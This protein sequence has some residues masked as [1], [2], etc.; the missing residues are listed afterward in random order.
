MTLDNID[1]KILVRTLEGSHR[2]REVARIG[3]NDMSEL[4]V[5][6][7]PKVG[8]PRKYTPKQLVEKFSEY[9]TERMCHPIEIEESKDGATGQNATWEKKTRSIPQMLSVAD[10]CVYLGCSRNWWNELPDEFLGVKEYISTYIDNF[11][12]K[13]AAAGVFNANIVSRLLGL[14]DKKQVSAGEG[15]TIIVKDNDQKEKLENMGSL[16]V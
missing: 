8:R 5:P 9:I 14:A 16:G 1:N 7:I 10:F 13:G 12:M 4:F 11:Q 3:G 15:V 6:F 2:Q